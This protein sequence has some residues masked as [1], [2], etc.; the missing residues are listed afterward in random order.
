MR[1]T[2]PFVGEV[3]VPDRK[4]RL[5]AL[6]DDRREGQRGRA[7]ARDVK[8]RST[9]ACSSP[10]PTRPAVASKSIQSTAVA[11]RRAFELLVRLFQPPMVAK[12]PTPM[13][14]LRTTAAD[15]KMRP[16]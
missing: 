10:A 15:P 5:D 14:T 11:T 16:K 2:V 9:A 3:A 13:P 12:S 6:A 1:P 8:A 4:R 7:Q